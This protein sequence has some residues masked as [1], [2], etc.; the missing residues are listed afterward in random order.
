V[1]RIT[2]L[3]DEGCLWLTG[4]IVSPG[5]AKA[6]TVKFLVD[7]GSST[8]ILSLRDAEVMGLDVGSLPRSPKKTGG[9]GGRIELRLLNH[10]MLVLASDDLK[11]KTVLLPS[12]GVQYSPL[13]ERREER[14][15]YSIPSVVGADAFAAG[16]LT[17]WADWTL[18]QGH[19]DYVE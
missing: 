10:V 16:G 9:Y 5:L 15:I 18:G 19:F 13:K 11:P 8:T 1:S 14:M 12:V 2:L 17:L 3:F 7:T 6:S 4:Q